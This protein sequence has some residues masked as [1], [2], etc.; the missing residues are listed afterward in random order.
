MLCT[1]TVEHIFFLN[2]YRTFTKNGY[3]PHLHH[4]RQEHLVINMYPSHSG[5]QKVT[6][7]PKPFLF[8]F[9]GSKKKQSQSS[10]S[11]KK[12]KSMVHTKAIDQS[13]HFIFLITL[14]SQQ[15]WAHAVSYSIMWC[16]PLNHW[17][18]LS[19][20]L[21]LSHI[22]VFEEFSVFTTVGFQQTPSILNS[23][24]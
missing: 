15:N 7:P 9:I 13:T 22:A 24:I 1:K 5:S 11:V 19:Q 6:C 16:S 18:L 23:H 20:T 10:Y 17:L 4:S 8:S 3:I 2:A 21:S 12:K 14:V